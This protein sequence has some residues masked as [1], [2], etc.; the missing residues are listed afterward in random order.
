MSHVGSVIMVDAAMVDAM[1][2]VETLKHELHI[3][4]G[5]HTRDLQSFN[6]TAF[7]MPT[8]FPTFVTQINDALLAENGPNLA[9]LLRPTSPHGKDLVKEFRNP[10]VDGL[11]SLEVASCLDDLVSACDVKSV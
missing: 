1:L 2:M 10:T 7:K 3:S 8:N 5:F 4:P 11:Q 6:R 9:Y